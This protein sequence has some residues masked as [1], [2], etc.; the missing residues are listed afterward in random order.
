M[1]NWWFL[2][3]FWWICRFSKMCTL[4][5]L[6]WFVFSKLAKIVNFYQI[7][8]KSTANRKIH[9]KMTIFS[10]SEVLLRIFKKRSKKLFFIGDFWSFW[11]LSISISII[12]ASISTISIIFDGLAWDPS[13][14]IKSSKIEQIEGNWY[15]VIFHDFSINRLNWPILHWFSPNLAYFEANMG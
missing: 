13:K 10:I 11:G 12:W 5:A 14:I 1:A 2:W 7:Q 9:Q 4:F 6:Q 3:L 15:F 8:D